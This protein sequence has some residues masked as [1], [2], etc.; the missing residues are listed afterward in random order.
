M[1][2]PVAEAG[3]QR[4]TSHVDD[5]GAGSDLFDRP[6]PSAHTRPSRTATAWVGGRSAIMVWTV[7]PR[8]TTSAGV[9]TF[10][11][12]VAVLNDQVRNV[13]G[14]LLGVRGLG[15]GQVAVLGVH[16][17]DAGIDRRSSSPKQ[18]APTTRPPGSRHHADQD[19]IGDR[20]GV[21]EQVDVAGEQD[22]GQ[23][24][25]ERWRRRRRSRRTGRGRVRR[26]REVGDDCG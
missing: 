14:L 23:S 18:L 22:D 21:G 8:K 20:P 11:S 24:R 3:K 15:P 9:I 19:H 13:G 5:L 12:I 17:A 6:S 26:R 7:P 2:V 16:S 1:D 4:P 10:S 25:A